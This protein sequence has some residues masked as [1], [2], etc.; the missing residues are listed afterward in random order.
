VVLNLLTN[1]LDSSDDGGTVRI[2]MDAHGNRAMLT[3]TDDGCG[4]EPEVLEHIFEPFFTRRRGGQ[5]IGLGLSITERIVADHGGAIEAQSA[6]SGQGSTFRISL[7][8]AESQK[9]TDHRS[10]A[11]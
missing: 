10:Q 11:A 6:G 8:L 5:G 3:V 2:Q 9:E 7:P 1:A 4:M